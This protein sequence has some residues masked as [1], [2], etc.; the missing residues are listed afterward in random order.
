MDMETI[1]RINKE[2]LETAKKSLGSHSGNNE[3]V[4]DPMCCA[5]YVIAVII[6]VSSYF[7]LQNVKPTFLMKKVEVNNEQQ[8]EFDVLK[9]IILSIILG[10]LVLL[11]HQLLV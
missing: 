1:K 7:I 2:A 5:V 8:M 4:L 11:S 10:L 6:S 3:M 9:A